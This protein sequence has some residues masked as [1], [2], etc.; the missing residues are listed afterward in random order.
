MNTCVPHRLVSQSPP[1]KGAIEKVVR[2]LGI[3]EACDLLKVIVPS[4]SSYRRK[5][6]E[7]ASRFS[8]NTAWK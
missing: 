2:L 7:A 1:L 4:S 3:H 8:S 5:I 6:T